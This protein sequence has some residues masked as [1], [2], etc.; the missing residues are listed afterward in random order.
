MTLGGG[1]MMALIQ[2]GGGIILAPDIER[3]EGRGRK[4]M[5]RLAF[6]VGESIEKS[7]YRCDDVALILLVRLN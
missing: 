7:R 3:D 2:F 5:V 4:A 6:G 1:I